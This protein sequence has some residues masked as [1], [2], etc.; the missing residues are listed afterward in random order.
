VWGLTGGQAAG[1]AQVLAGAGEEGKTVTELLEM[2]SLSGAFASP[3]VYSCRVAQSTAAIATQ[4]SSL[5]GHI[6]ARHDRPHTCTPTLLVAPSHVCGRLA[7][8]PAG[9]DFGE[10]KTPLGALKS[11]LN[12][13][14]QSFVWVR[15]HAATPLQLPPAW[16]VADGAA[17][18]AWRAAG[19]QVHVRAASGGACVGRGAGRRHL[20]HRA[21]YGLAWR[22]LAG[23]SP[24]GA[25]CRG[26]V[27]SEAP[28]R[29]RRNGTCTCERT[30]GVAQGLGGLRSPGG[31][32]RRA[33]PKP[34]V[35]LGVL[36][37]EEG[38][39]Q[40]RFAATGFPLPGGLQGDKGR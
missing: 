20:R 21:S 5:P 19:G 34:A 17:R 7:A 10:K 31:E 36:R 25:W 3:H 18:G 37:E 30:R 11:L 13:N 22:P 32:R 39:V 16:V 14:H 8:C 15:A 6:P 35:E 28:H 24:P 27:W 26:G 12:A 40:V 38:W 33:R 9:L 4:P 29:P 2:P 1:S 23:A